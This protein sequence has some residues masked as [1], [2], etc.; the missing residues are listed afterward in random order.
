MKHLLLTLTALAVGSL[1]AFP[2]ELNLNVFRHG[3]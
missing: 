3:Q 1:V 2:H